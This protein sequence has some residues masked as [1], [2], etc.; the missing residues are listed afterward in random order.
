MSVSY[1]LSN[2]ELEILAVAK[3][4]GGLTAREISRVANRFGI[5]EVDFVKELLAHL[6]GRGYIST[7]WDESLN[8]KTVDITQKGIEEI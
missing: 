3:E 8:D 6:E 2:Q 7:T 4:V 5:M 1:F